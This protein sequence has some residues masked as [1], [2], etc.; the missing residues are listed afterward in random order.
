MT[1]K[2]S[3]G[4]MLKAA[5]GPVAEASVV[6]GSVGGLPSSMVV[7]G[8]VDEVMDGSMDEDDGVVERTKITS[9][10]ILS[11]LS[12]FCVLPVV[13][14]AVVWDAVTVEAVVVVVPMGLE[15]VSNGVAD[16]VEEE[17]GA[18]VVVVEVITG[19]DVIVVA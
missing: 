17:E 3:L 13:R 18:G 16:R 7:D 1:G 19:D 14:S 5:V 11:P 9:S 15:L 4:R 2:V 8:S 6:A 12:F 10:F